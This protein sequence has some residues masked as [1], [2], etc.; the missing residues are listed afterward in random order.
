MFK[1]NLKK[2]LALLASVLILCTL[3]PLSSLL[4]AGAAGENLVINGDFENGKEE[5][6]CNSGESEIV[7][8]A[9]GGSSALQLTNPGMWAEAGVQTIDVDPNSD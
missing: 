2:A 5:W 4:T 6:A 1:N 7:T 3:L 9:H 8:D